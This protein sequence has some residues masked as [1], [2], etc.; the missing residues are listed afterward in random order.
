MRD[1]PFDPEKFRLTPQQQ[2]NLSTA[3]PK[4]ERHRREKFVK[5]PELCKRPLDPTFISVW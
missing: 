3:K 1:D 5:V 2:S 4:P